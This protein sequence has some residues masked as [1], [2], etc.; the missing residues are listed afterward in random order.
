MKITIDT[1]HSNFNRI[2]IAGRLDVGGV[3]AIEDSFNAATVEAG[4][5]AIV[6][7]TEVP[8]I[9]SMALRMLL[10][11][12]KSMAKEKKHLVLLKPHE[13]AD[14]YLRS[15]NFYSL[16]AVTYSEQDAYGYLED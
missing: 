2:E 7:L 14:S 4:K 8:L 6:V 15:V 16:V 12:A 1:S 3:E 10:M 11:A 13:K 5:N 9:T